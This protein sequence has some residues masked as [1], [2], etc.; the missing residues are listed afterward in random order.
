MID[1]RRFARAAHGVEGEDF[2]AAF[3]PSLV[4]R[5]HLAVAAV[6][7]LRVGVRQLGNIDIRCDKGED[8]FASAC[9]LCRTDDVSVIVIIVFERTLGGRNHIS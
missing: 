6:K 2:G 5:G 1:E 9:L 8:A 4:Q 3:V 7:L